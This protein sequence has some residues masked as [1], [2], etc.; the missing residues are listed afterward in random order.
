MTKWLPRIGTITFTLWGLLHIAGGALMLNAANVQ[1]GAAYF[2]MSA[3]AGMADGADLPGAAF[4]IFTARSMDLIWVG[5]LITLLAWRFN[6]R[7]SGNWWL[8]PLIIGAVEIVLVLSTIR[9]G[10]M[11]FGQASPGLVLAIAAIVSVIAGRP[12]VAA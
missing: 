9:P 12:R 4:A 1:D 7:N 10:F 11:T 5:A 8:A 3:P 2:E 6:W